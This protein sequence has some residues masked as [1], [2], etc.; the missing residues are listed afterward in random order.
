MRFSIR[1]LIAVT[2]YVALVAA[3]IGTRNSILVEV[4]WAVSLLAICYAI[5][6]AAIHPGKRRA[7]AV[8]F[9][10]LA[11]IHIACVY[12][13]GAKTPATWPYRAAGYSVSNNAVYE[14]VLS[15]T[16]SRPTRMT[17]RTAEV[18]PSI[19]LANGVVTLLAGFLGSWIG[20]LAFKQRA[21]SC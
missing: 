12:V 16:A 21:L 5:V 17:L 2:T 11:A 3:A 4:V 8:G 1:W 9:V 6:V 10:A 18:M 15:P 14:R 20:A 19:S 13:A 7:M